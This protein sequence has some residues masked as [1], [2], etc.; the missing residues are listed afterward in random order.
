[1]RLPGKR[2][3]PLALT[4]SVALLLWALAAARGHG[5]EMI[6]LPAA[7]AGAAW[8]QHL[9]RSLEQCLRRLRRRERRHQPDAS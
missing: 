6:W 3:F 4:T 7:A 5:W 9:K 8:P 1:M 2:W